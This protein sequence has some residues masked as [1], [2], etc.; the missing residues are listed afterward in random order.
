MTF[1]QDPVVV[2]DDCWLGRPAQLIKCQ[3]AALTHFRTHLM[4]VVAVLDDPL[5]MIN[6]G[7]QK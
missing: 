4:I 1:Y 2:V 7:F 3:A 5:L 6:D